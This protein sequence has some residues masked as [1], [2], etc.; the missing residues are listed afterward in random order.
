MVRIGQVSLL[1]N[2]CTDLRRTQ[3]YPVSILEGTSI[4][5]FGR[6]ERILAV[7]GWGGGTEKSTKFCKCGSFLRDVYFHG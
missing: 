5:R 7:K 6:A 3:F 2:I 1:I 4:K